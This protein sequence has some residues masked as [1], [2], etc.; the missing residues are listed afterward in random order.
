VRNEILSLLYQSFPVS[1]WKE[2]SRRARTA[3]VRRLRDALA[4]VRD[5]IPPRGSI[6]DLPWTVGDTADGSVEQFRAT[7]SRL[8]QGVD[9]KL[10]RL[11]ATPTHR[12]PNPK[13]AFR[14]FTP[15]LI[16]IYEKMT[17]RQAKKPY[18]RDDSGNY[19][20]QFYRFAVAV[21]QAIRSCL[22]SYMDALPR[23]EGALAQ[24]LQDHWPA[25]GYEGG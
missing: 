8:Y 24:E 22:P 7:I 11:E 5:A 9:E 4:L 10:R 13:T 16:W 14:D 23:S 25:P 6:M 19:G 12:G 21:W 3:K 1:P 2:P 15:D 20:G 17:G 18:W